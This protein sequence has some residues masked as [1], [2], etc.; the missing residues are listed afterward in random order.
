MLA[1]STT[2]DISAAK[3]EL[4]YRPRVSVEEGAER[5]LKWWKQQT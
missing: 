3:N 2:L 4:G 1:H 5:F